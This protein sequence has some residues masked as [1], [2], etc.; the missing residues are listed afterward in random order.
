MRTIVSVAVSLDGFTADDSGSRLM[1]SSPED[2]DAVYR[3]RAESDAIL[4]G[5]QTVRVDNPSLATRHA[6]CFELRKQRGMTPHPLKATIT[7]SGNLPADAKFFQEG[8]AQKLV[9]CGAAADPSLEKRLGSLATVVRFAEQDV[10]ASAVVA[11]LAKR[12]VSQLMVEGGAR[13]IDLFF[14]AGVVDVLRLAVAP[15][16]C[17]KRGRSRPFSEPFA[18]WA[19]RRRIRLEKT[20]QLGDTAVMWYQLERTDDLAG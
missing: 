9:F 2:F 14:R 16:I 10:V 6:A 3:L 11:D 18:Q 1:L 17:G 12:G 4:V 8:D 13:T 15:V 5:G 20:E 19:D 7:A